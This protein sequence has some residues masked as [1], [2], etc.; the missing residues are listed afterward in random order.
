[1]TGIGLLHPGAMG[2]F[3]GKALVSNGNDVYWC[4][5]SRSPET[6]RRADEAKLIGVDSIDRL[7][8][9]CSTI[10]SVCPPHKAMDVA[11]QVFDC[12]FSGVYV[13]ANAISPHKTRAMAERASRRDIDF[14]D[15]GIIGLPSRSASVPTTLYLSGSK[16]NQIA[17]LF[18][19]SDVATHVISEEIGAASVMKMCFA[20]YTKGR[21]ALLANILALACREGVLSTL[22]EQ[23]GS[24]FTE[25]VNTHIVRDAQKAWR[26]EGEMHEIAR[27]FKEGKLPDGFHLAAAETYHRLAFLRRE[28]EPKLINVLQ[29]LHSK[30]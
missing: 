14:V 24:A 10:L 30:S 9:K 17:D 12:G 21:T 22:Q 4:S 2:S 3:V 11:V 6:I 28:P 26:F 8:S 15:G 27:T 25:E 16:A 19:R 23:W 13:D 7:G 5:S 1:M 18:Q 20:A 29:A